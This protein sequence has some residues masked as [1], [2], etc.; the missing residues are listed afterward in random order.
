[1]GLFAKA[2]QLVGKAGETI[3]DVTAKAAAKSEGW[4]AKADAFLGDVLQKAADAVKENKEAPV[5][6][7]PREPEAAETVTPVE[8][9]DIVIV[10][11][12]TEDT[13]LNDE[14]VKESHRTIREDP[15]LYNSATD[16]P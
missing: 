9:V 4:G 5:P 3:G 2:E 15:K 10:P 7:Y 16:L 1:M 6:T 12:T 11:E 8:I 13:V 14:T